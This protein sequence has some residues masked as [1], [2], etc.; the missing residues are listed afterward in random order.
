MVR[1]LV[2]RGADI[3]ATGYPQR[4]ALYYAADKGH[5]EM[6][7][8][9]LSQGAQVDITDENGWTPLA[10]A[11]SGGHVGVVKM[12]LQHMGGQGLD[13]ADNQGRTALYHAA[14]EGHEEIVA[15]LLSQGAHADMTDECGWTPFTRAA[16]GGHLGVVKMLLQ[17]MGGQGLDQADRE[18]R[19]A[20]FY[21]IEEGHAE[22]VGYV[23][24]QG[25]QWNIKDPQG[26]TPLIVAIKKGHVGVA[27]MLLQHMGEQ[28]LDQT[29]SSRM[30]ALHHASRQGHE[31]IVAFLLSQ[32]ARVDL[33]GPAGN[34]PL[35]E[36]AGWKR[37][38][39]VKM[40]LQHMGGK[41]LNQRNFHGW[42][43]LH[44]ASVVG[45]EEIVRAL[46][47][48][49]ADPTIT[50]H[51]GETPRAVAHD[52]RRQGCVEVFDVSMQQSLLALHSRMPMNMPITL[53][54][55]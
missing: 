43:A 53:I 54:S 26:R 8:F 10:I 9:L 20:L 41:G 55:G 36:A 5:E 23:L 15:L 2:A 16:S 32:G 45:H 13:Q 1:L 30:T 40:L 22:V 3:Q 11:A 4:T 42:T 24:S 7:A 39:V 19:T 52:T 37:L 46:L 28:G 12:L 14:R 27:K 29:D 6:V 51:K 33:K 44:D 17:H 48:A 34:T 31:E 25:A 35:I 18:G 47:F 49:G 38:G 50:E 21:A